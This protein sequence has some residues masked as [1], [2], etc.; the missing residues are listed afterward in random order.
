MGKISPFC[1]FFFKAKLAWTKFSRFYFKMICSISPGEL[2]RES[3][4]D[5]IRDKDAIF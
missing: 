5:F 4:E 1:E 3:L 2:L